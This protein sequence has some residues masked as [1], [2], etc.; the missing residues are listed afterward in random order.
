MNSVTFINKPKNIGG[1]GTFQKNFTNF[2][3]KLSINVYLFDEKHVP[4]NII[5]ISGTKRLYYL[6]K[7][8]YLDDARIIQRLDGFEFLSIRKYGLKAFLKNRIQFLLITLIMVCIADE[9]IFQSHFVKNWWRRKLF[10]YLP[11]NTSVICNGFNPSFVHCQKRRN[12]GS[13]RLISVEGAVKVDDYTKSLLY[14]YDSVLRERDKGECLEVY[15]NLEAEVSEKFTNV[16]FKGRIGRSSVANVYMNGRPIFVLLECQA[17][18]PNSLV[19]AVGAGVPSIGSDDGSFVE[20][21]EGSGMSFES[22]LISADGEELKRQIANQLTFIDNNYIHFFE[23][24]VLRSNTLT[25]NKM[26]DEYLKVLGNN[27]CA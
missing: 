12:K 3:R 22:R 20:L 26:M 14:A 13:I 2:C 17:A 6:I 19:E 9:I 7:S 10:K 11:K 25:L 16:S 8:K 5:V 23:L 15:G 4:E 27:K 1:P 24:A 18:C 21:A